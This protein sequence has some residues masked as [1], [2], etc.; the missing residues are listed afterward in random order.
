MKKTWLVIRNE[1]LSVFLRPSYW[2]TLLLIPLTS[3]IILLII[4]GL[5]KSTGVDAGD[6]IGELFMPTTSNDSEGFVDQSGL[7]QLIPEDSADRLTRYTAEDLARQAVERGEISA[8]YIIPDDF[9]ESG[10]IFYIRPD[11]NPLGGM[12]QTSALDAL[13]A[14]NLMEGNQEMSYRIQNPVNVEEVDLSNTLQRDSANMLTFFLPYVVTFMFY[15][16]ILS[17]ASLLL[18]NISNEKQNRVLELLMTSVNAKQLLTGKIIA[19]GITGLLQTVFWSSAGLL[20]LRFSGR[21]F[22]LSSAFQ[23]P[24][25]VLLWGIL[26]FLLGYAVYAS[27]MAGIGALV[28]SLKE[29]SQLTTIVILPLIVP[30]MFISTL[31]QTPN[32]PLAIALSFIPLTSPVSMMTRLSATSVPFWQPALAVLLLIGT[33]FLLVRASASLFRAQNL[34]SGKAVNTIAFFKALAGK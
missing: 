6:A 22:N 18:N 15:I 13:V 11:Y 31:I 8:Y 19:L 28:P 10:D 9:L 3:F 25:S 21:A 4:S 29:A 5:Q 17:S 30:L 1:F 7:M 32:S 26:F 14:Y 12:T 16:I 34:L 33:A 20:M 2:L 23:L 27:L 24:V